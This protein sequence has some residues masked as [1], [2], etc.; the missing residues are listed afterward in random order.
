MKTTFLL[1]FCFI[2][3]LHAQKTKV[4]IL[5]STITTISSTSIYPVSIHNKNYKIQQSI[6]QYAMIGEKRIGKIKVQQGFLTNNKVFNINNSNL[7]FIDTSLNVQISPNPFID[8]I[9]INFSKE[10]VNDIQINI[11]DLNGK[12]LFSKKYKP[13]D[14]LFVPMRFYSI[15]SYVI[16]I[17][18][19]TTKITKKLIKTALK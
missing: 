8:H 17:Q 4:T 19:G 2:A 1:V 10:T 5:R 16:R 6:G 9:K 18:S 15:G 14:V 3:Q 7:E 11:Y 13:T 12:V